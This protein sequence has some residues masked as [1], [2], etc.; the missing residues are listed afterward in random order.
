MAN[1]MTSM[2]AHQRALGLYA[3]TGAVSA[4]LA[5]YAAELDR[6]SDELSELLQNS[7]LATMD[8]DTA[9][10]YER[11][12]GP[13]RNSLPIADRRQMLSDR[14]SLNSSSFTLDEFEKALMSFGFDYT[15]AEYPRFSRLN[16]IAEG[17]YSE[18]EQRYIT[19]EI[20]KFCPAQV[21]VQVVFNTL[22]WQELDDRELSFE[23]LDGMDLTWEQTDSQGGQH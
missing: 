8:A 7:F 4:E 18:A 1:S 2:A 11:L 20:E 19:R 16:V 15:L 17:D 3:A 10:V 12:F 6:V 22:S 23:Q 5:A 14:F 9:S 21:E 13:E